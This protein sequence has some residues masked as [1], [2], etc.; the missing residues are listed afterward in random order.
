MKGKYYLFRAGQ[1]V[2][3][4]L[5]SADVDSMDRASYL[6]NKKHGKVIFGR[7]CVVVR[8]DMNTMSKLMP[9]RDKFGDHALIVISGYKN[10]SV[11][12]GVTCTG[13]CSTERPLCDSAGEVAIRQ[14]REM[15]ARVKCDTH[16]KH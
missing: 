15:L 9:D 6:H 10:A 2:P 11:I 14:M 4:W 8:G 1:N 3:S 12:G 13:I 5:L 7:T 16:L